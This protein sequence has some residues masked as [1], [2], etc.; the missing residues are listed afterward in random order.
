MYKPCVHYIVAG[1]TYKH[2]QA[3]CPLHSDRYRI[4]ACTSTMSTTQRQVPHT[5]MY[6]HCVHYIVTGTAYKHV[7]ALCP[8]HSGRY[9][10]QACT[11]TVSTI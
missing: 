8:L 7:Q 5:S 11:S 9:C 3:L 2:V 6:K 1:T 10:I 4:Q